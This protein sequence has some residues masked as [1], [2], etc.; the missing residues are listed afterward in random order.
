MYTPTT[1][2]LLLALPALAH[3]TGL[4]IVTNNCPF[5]SYLWSVNS[6]TTG[7]E[8]TLAANG[9]TH[10]T[11][12]ETYRGSGIV[13]K[14]SR[15]SSESSLYDPNTPLTQFQYTLDGTTVYYDLADTRGDPYLG[16]PVTLKPSD[17]SC[18]TVTWSNGT[19]PSA[20]YTCGSA[21]NLTLTLC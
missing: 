15:N 11:Y 9:T 10:S 6:T 16:Y 21:A 19:G 3:A 4:A 2:Y 5:P 8:Q 18:T 12:G 13:L 20:V 17:P 14:L 1:S 7:P